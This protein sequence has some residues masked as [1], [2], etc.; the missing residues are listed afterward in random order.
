MADPAKA[1]ETMIQ[2][3]EAKTGLTMKELSESIAE[4]GL[5][6]HGQIVSMLKER[7]GL[8]HGHAN[9]VAHLAR[10]S[11]GQADPQNA[12]R[13]GG[14]S[15]DQVLDDL[16]VG[17]KE[18]LRPVHDRI[19][20]FLGTLGDFEVAPKKGY[21]SYRRKKQFAMVGPKTNSQVEVGLAAKVL[22]ADERLKEMPTGSMCRYTTRLSSPDEVD[23]TLESWLRASYGEAE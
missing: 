2:N 23:G 12:A 17:K 6:K 14:Q 7:F 13:S 18:H 3:I 15:G 20:S 10:Q 9:T 8:G 4:S 1:L 22:P 5:E 21:V 19:L 16:Y 11:D